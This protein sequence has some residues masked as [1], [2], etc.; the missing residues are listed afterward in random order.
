LA[1]EKNTLD[2]IRE[3]PKIV[4]WIA[5]ARKQKEIDPRHARFGLKY[6]K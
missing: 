1:E 4:S 6:K 5:Y 2:K 3:D